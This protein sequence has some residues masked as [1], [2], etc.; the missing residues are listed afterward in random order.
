MVR[1]V[2]MILVF[3][4]ALFTYD[5]YLPMGFEMEGRAVPEGVV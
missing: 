3:E 4:F 5:N 2:L 1:V